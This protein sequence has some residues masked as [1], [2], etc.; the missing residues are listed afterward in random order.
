MPSKPV[1]TLY[2]LRCS[3]VA[4]AYSRRETCLQMR[5]FGCRASSMTG[6]SSLG[7]TNYLQGLHYAAHGG[8][9]QATL[10]NALVE[11][12]GYNNRLQVQTI[13]LGTLLTVTND[14]GPAGTNNGNVMGQSIYDGTTTRT[15][16]FGY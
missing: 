3:K 12:T 10:G 1:L 13:G 2:S 16:T 9:A 14:Y 15:Q 5:T 4:A 7:P 11:S 6:Q 8:L